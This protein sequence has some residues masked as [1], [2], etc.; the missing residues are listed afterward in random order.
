MRVDKPGDFR[1]NEIW[2]KQKIVHYAAG[3]TYIAAAEEYMRDVIVHKSYGTFS[4][5]PTAVQFLLLLSALLFLV[6][7]ILP[8]PLQLRIRLV[9]AFLGVIQYAQLLGIVL[10]A[11]VMLTAT[12]FSLVLLIPSSALPLFLVWVL[13]RSR[14]RLVKLGLGQ[15]QAR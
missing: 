12:P 8:N 15:Q 6:E 10:V 14:K 13:R 4:D 7:A 5:V 1:F 3:L 2:M 11:F 9:V